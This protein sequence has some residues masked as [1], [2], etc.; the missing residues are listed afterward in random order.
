VADESNDLADAVGRHA[1]A[2]QEFVRI[3]QQIRDRLAAR[4]RRRSWPPLVAVLALVL[5]ASPM[6]VVGRSHFVPAPRVGQQ[7]CPPA[8]AHPNADCTGVPAGTT[9]TELPLN[10]DGEAYQVT[11]NGAVLDSVHIAGFLLI[12][13]DNVTVKNSKVDQMISTVNGN[14]VYH[15]PTLIQD[16]TIGP[17]TGPCI[18][19]QGI[20]G[21]DF[22]ALRIEIQNISTGFQASSVNGMTTHTGPV[23]VRDSFAVNCGTPPEVTPPDGSH[24]SGFQGCV[25]V[26]CVDVTL[27][28]NTLDDRNLYHTAPITVGA[29]AG[30]VTGLTLTN[31]FLLGGTYPIYIKWH[32]GPNFTVTGNHIAQ[33]T[34]DYLP[35]SGE[36]T[37]ANQNWSGNKIVTWDNATYQTTS[38]VNSVD[39][40]SNITGP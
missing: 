10:L 11:T 33:N 16:T 20:T 40:D 30:I 4:R 5:A 2:T 24:A 35:V 12:N 14:D 37:C 13:A 17:D 28:H 36:S 15:G 26:D 27:D 31:N 19:N 29:G 1:R 38:L 25:G 34:W 23:I 39:C 22:T 7:S 6:A 32:Q 3:E 21:N 8:P 18:N 9:L